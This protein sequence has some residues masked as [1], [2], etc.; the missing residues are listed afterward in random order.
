[1]NDDNETVASGEVCPCR[2]SLVYALESTVRLSARFWPS[3]TL[4]EHMAGTRAAPAEHTRRTGGAV[5]VMVTAEPSP[6]RCSWVHRMRAGG[7][8]FGS[9]RNGRRYSV[10]VGARRRTL[11]CRQRQPPRL[12]RLRLPRLLLLPYRRP[13]NG[14]R[15]AAPRRKSQLRSPRPS[16]PSRPAARRVRGHRPW[17]SMS[18]TP[19]AWWWR[20]CTTVP[21]AELAVPAPGTRS[22]TPFLS[23]GA[24]AAVQHVRSRYHHAAVCFP[25]PPGSGPRH[26]LLWNYEQCGWERWKVLHVLQRGQRPGRIAAVLF[27]R[28]LPGQRRWFRT[29]T[30]ETGRVPSRSPPWMRP[31]PTCRAPNTST[32]SE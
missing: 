7:H 23:G 13:N 28:R 30:L 20:P 16:G 6:Q 11:C 15:S 14:G 1:M 10:G 19:R 4:G 3:L 22:L 8:G 29:Q 21:P 5:Q 17:T 26:C 18:R 2:C 32:R 25:G 31:G 24:C 12:P 27:C 9:E